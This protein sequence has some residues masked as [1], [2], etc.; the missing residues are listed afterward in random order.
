MYQLYN[1]LYMLGLESLCAVHSLE[2]L[3][4]K[5]KLFASISLLE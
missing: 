3:F 1:V 4:F 2:A 5:V